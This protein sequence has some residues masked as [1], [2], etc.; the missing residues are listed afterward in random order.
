M[1]FF[2]HPT[3]RNIFDHVNS[4]SAESFEEP[5]HKVVAKYHDLGKLSREFQKY[6]TLKKGEDE[7]NREFE[8]RRAKL[9]TTHTLE[10]AYLYFCSETERGDEFLSN[11]FAILKHHTSLPNIQ[12]NINGYL[13]TIDNYID[14]SRL[15]R[16]EDIAYRNNIELPEDIYE[17]IDFFEDLYEEDLYQNYNELLSLQK[18]LL[19]PK[20]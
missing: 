15:E 17:S 1:D 16:I 9:K 11:F 3:Y 5:H 12:E 14:D 13:S 10:S 2:S 4:Y 18:T 6:I 7:D 20:Y 19:S 8:K